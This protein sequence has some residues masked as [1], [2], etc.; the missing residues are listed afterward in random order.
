M[1][2]L[3]SKSVQKA[4]ILPAH[5]KAK[6]LLHREYTPTLDYVL[7]LSLFCLSFQHMIGQYKFWYNEI[8]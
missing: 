4:T 6:F 8:G 3:R 5:V 2:I 7:Y 1:S